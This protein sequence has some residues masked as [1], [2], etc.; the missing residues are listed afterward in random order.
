M[1]TFRQLG[2]TKAYATTTIVTKIVLEIVIETVR[3]RHIAI[4]H[5][6]QVVTKTVTRSVDTL[7]IGYLCKEVGCR[8]HL[9]A[10]DKGSTVQV[11]VDRRTYAVV[12]LF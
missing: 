4:D 5:Q 1:L 3:H 8:I 7:L 6:L 10:I 2:Q 9:A 11:T 12:A